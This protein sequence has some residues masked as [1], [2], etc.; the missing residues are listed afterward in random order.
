MSKGVIKEGGVG[1]GPDLL[2]GSNIPDHRSQMPVNPQAAP[3]SI[4]KQQLNPNA[5]RISN[6]RIF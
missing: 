4:N 3:S 1:D 5:N 6:A 2:L